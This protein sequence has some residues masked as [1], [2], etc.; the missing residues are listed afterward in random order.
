[1]AFRLSVAQTGLHSPWDDLIYAMAG[2]DLSTIAL[3]KGI[4]S[5]ESEWNPGAINP[6]DPSYGLMQILL[7]PGGPFP[8]VRADD[9]LDP[10]TNI[11]LGSTFIMDLLRRYGSPG[12]I[13]AYNAGSPRLNAAGQYVNSRGDTMVQAYVDSVLTYQT[14][15]LNQML[16]A[17]PDA[18]LTVGGP[19]E[20]AGGG[21]G[22]TSGLSDILRGIYDPPGAETPWYD[23]YAGDAYYEPN[24]MYTTQGTPSVGGITTGA[25]VALGLLAVGAVWMSRR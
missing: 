1:M 10:S 3:I 15:F 16:D 23:P 2:G 6:S 4:I 17:P 14:W 7:G 12:A 5:T 25:M 11:T 9:L 18:I 21:G 8:T 22:W 20:P 13:A 24:T 19:V